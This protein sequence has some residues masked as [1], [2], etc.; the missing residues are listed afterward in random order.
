MS[1]TKVFELLKLAL[2]VLLLGS[3]TACQGPTEGDGALGCRTSTAAA[4]L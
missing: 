2:V 1:M 3:A 4:T